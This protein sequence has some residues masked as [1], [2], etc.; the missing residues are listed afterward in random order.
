MFF[1]VFTLKIIY[2]YLFIKL[3]FIGYQKQGVKNS[4]VYVILLVSSVIQ[5]YLRKGFFGPM[6]KLLEE[7]EDILHEAT[8]VTSEY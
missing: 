5:R 3:I 1:R 2:I 7:Y 6:G 8:Y 4:I